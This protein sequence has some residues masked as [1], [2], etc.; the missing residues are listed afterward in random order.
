MTV[1]NH[2]WYVC[3]R[4]IRHKGPKVKVG[5]ENIFNQLRRRPPRERPAHSSNVRF[6]RRAERTKFA[7]FSPGSM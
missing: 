2:L 1:S 7:V 3:N 5:A 6:W 4:G